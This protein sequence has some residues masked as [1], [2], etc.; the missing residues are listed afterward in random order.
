MLLR[1]KI[2]IT[3]IAKKRLLKGKSTK[4]HHDVMQKLTNGLFASIV[5]INCNLN[6]SFTLKSLYAIST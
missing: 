5:K 4:N 6:L 3:W 2:N 1:G